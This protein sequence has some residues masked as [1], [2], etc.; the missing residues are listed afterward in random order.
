MVLSCSYWLSAWLLYSKKEISIYSQII[1]YPMC[2]SIQHVTSQHLTSAFATFFHTRSPILQHLI[3]LSPWFSIYYSIRCNHWKAR[4]TSYLHNFSTH[5]WITENV[6]PQWPKSFL[7]S[8]TNTVGLDS[9]LFDP[10]GFWFC[11]REIRL[12]CP[13]VAAA[14]QWVGAEGAFLLDWPLFYYPRGT[15]FYS[16]SPAVQ[17]SAAD[18]P[19]RRDTKRLLRQSQRLDESGGCRPGCCF[20]RVSLSGR[21]FLILWFRLFHHPSIPFFENRCMGKSVKK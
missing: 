6:W 11:G 12:V 18:T 8:R 5:S 17:E 16:R 13:H 20:V 15:L 14:T 1:G 19:A 10:H 21:L 3:K 9:N 7:C 4:R 2:L